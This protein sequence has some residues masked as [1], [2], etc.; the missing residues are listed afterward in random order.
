MVTVSLPILKKKSGILLSDRIRTSINVLGDAFGAG[1]VHHFTKD[2]LALADAVHA[3]RQ[4][5]LAHNS[6]NNNESKNYS[7]KILGNKIRLT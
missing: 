1:I 5:E 7:Q 2:H 4:S 6:E 3:R